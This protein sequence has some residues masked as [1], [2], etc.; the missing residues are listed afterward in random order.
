LG[1]SLGEET[2]SIQVS[3]WLALLLC[4][5][6]C[7]ELAFAQTQMLLSASLF[8]K[9]KFLTSKPSRLKKVE[10]KSSQICRYHKGEKKKRLSKGKESLS[11]PRIS[12]LLR[13][14]HCLYAIRC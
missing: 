4:G 6:Q 1:A 13:I 3:P 11:I 10:E 2:S 8:Q 5:L 9:K 7:L 14:K 12:P